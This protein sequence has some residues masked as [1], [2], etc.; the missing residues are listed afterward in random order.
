MHT[1]I[2]GADI[3]ACNAEAKRMSAGHH[4]KEFDFSQNRSNGVSLSLIQSARETA[5]APAV[6]GCEQRTVLLLNMHMVDGATKSCLKSLLE[7]SQSRVIITASTSA[8]IPH[9]ITS[10]CCVVRVRHP[11]LLRRASRMHESEMYAATRRVVDACA[12]RSVGSKVLLRMAHHLGAACARAAVPFHVWAQFL[13]EAVSD[14]PQA[15][16]IAIK[17]AEHDAMD[18]VAGRPVVLAWL[19]AVVSTAVELRKQRPI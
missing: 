8:S 15:F 4:T 11:E 13:I 18:A 5:E 17:V 10:F 2:I 6:M 19:G 9:V 3:A 16:D 1:L 7:N 12:N 14:R